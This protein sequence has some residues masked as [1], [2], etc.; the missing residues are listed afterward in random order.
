MHPMHLDGVA[1][2]E[3]TVLTFADRFRGRCQLRLAQFLA[4][5]ALVAAFITMP[6]A[7]AGINGEGLCL[8]LRVLVKVDVAQ[9]HF[10][11]ARRHC[12]GAL[13]FTLQAVNIARSLRTETHACRARHTMLSTVSCMPVTGITRHSAGREQAQRHYQTSITSLDQFH[14]KS[15]MN[16]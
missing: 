13:V 10:P 11:G 14:L 8:V 9:I 16:V 1:R 15:L 2:L 5:I 3:L 12:K 4:D 7:V 6:I